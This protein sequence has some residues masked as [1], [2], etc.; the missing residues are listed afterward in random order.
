MVYV[1]CQGIGFLIH[2]CHKKYP[3]LLGHTPVVQSQILFGHPLYLTFV[4]YNDN[5]NVLVE[6]G[7]RIAI[8][9]LGGDGEDAAQ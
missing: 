9:I 6:V 5:R 7:D 8:S 1:D 2:F 3:A 4:V